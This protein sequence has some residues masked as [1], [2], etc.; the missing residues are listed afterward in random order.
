MHLT[1]AVLDTHNYPKFPRLSIYS[2]LHYGPRARKHRFLKSIWKLGTFSQWPAQITLYFG[3]SSD[4]A[5]LCGSV[6][7][8]KIGWNW[9][10]YNF[11]LWF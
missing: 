6:K 2:A 7:P 8:V 10:D 4:C 5:E 3:Y 11:Y 1:A 9:L